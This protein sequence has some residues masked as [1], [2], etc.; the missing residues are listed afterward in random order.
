MGISSTWVK[1]IRLTYSARRGAGFAVGQRPVALFRHSHP[2]TEM[3]FV[4]RNRRL[5][6]ISFPA[7]FHPLLVGPLVVEIPDDRSRTRRLFVKHA[8][9]V[10]FLA[11]VSLIVGN[12]VVLVQRALAD[13]GHKAFPDTGTPACLKQMRLCVPAIEIADDRNRTGVGCPHPKVCSWLSRN[14]SEVSAQL[15]VNPVVGTLVEEMEILISQQAG[16]AAWTRG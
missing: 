4:D 10:G 16:I 9:R 3:N 12:D 11:D 2:G 5:Q 1:F 6:R 13:S 8:K 15:V 7:R 14:R